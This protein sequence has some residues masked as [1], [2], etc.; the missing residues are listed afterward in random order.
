M[1]T[2]KKVTYLLFF[3][4]AVMSTYQCSSTKYKL[5]EKTT[6]QLDRVY[7][8]EWYAGIKVGGTGINIY[9][10]NLNSNN[11]VVVDSVFFRNLK[12]KLTKERSM[13]SAILKNRSP[14]DSTT[15]TKAVKYPF[16]L[17]GNECVISYI[18]DGETKYFKIVNV[19]EREGIYYE[20]GPPSR[21]VT[22][23]IE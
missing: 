8:Q 6:L 4:I 2:I 21:V 17:S 9:F 16:K 23:D 18:E 3:T 15:I 12:G 7:C 22:V 14:Y 13:Y 19:T 10:P 11:K 5:Q 1:K 20:N